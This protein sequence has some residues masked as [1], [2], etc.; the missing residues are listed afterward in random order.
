MLFLS[1]YR[2]PH[3]VRTERR[4]S[5]H[6][7]A[8]RNTHSSP[9]QREGSRAA[10]CSTLKYRQSRALDFLPSCIHMKSLPTSSDTASSTPPPRRVLGD[11]A[12]QLMM[13][14]E[15]TASSLECR[16]GLHEVPALWEK[17]PAVLIMHTYIRAAQPLPDRT[18]AACTILMSTPNPRVPPSTKT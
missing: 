14:S 8:T 5:K 10:L 6:G 15:H 11:T 17:R 13:S 16:R 12:T 2:V 18:A 4:Q 1:H 3:P 7:S 9:C